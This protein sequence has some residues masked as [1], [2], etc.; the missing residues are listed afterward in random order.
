MAKADVYKRQLQDILR[1]FYDTIQPFLHF[2]KPLAKAQT[3]LH[4][5]KLAFRPLDG[6]PDPLPG[7]S[8]VHGDF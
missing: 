1:G 4:L 6:I 7:D 5:Q 2:P 8:F 3:F